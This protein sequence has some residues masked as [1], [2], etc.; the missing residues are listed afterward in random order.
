MPYDNQFVVVVPDYRARI[1]AA[2]WRAGEVTAEIE[3][4]E[5]DLELQVLLLT[6]GTHEPLPSISSPSA[7]GPTKLEVPKGTERVE[8]FLVRPTGDL[9]DH[10]V[11]HKSGEEF[12]AV[13]GEPTPEE[14]A[15][16]DF[17]AGEGQDVEFKPF[18]TPNDN[19]KEDEFIRT[20]VAFAN[21][22][23]GRLYVGVKDTGIPEGESAL[24][25]ASKSDPVRGWTALADRISHLVRE[26]VKPIPKINVVQ[27]RVFGDPILMVEVEP[28]VDGPC[29]THEN[30]VYVRKGATNRKPDP[31]T[32]LPHIGSSQRSAILAGQLRSF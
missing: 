30:D 12:E 29:A 16:A 19:G 21:S 23:G 2:D 17:R 26:K 7:T 18:V 5:R 8:L 9:A 28:S 24:C 1:R 10:V 3:G 13:A 32:E 15:L 20:I 6:G 11:L 14:R 27:L 25:R 22:E 4:T 31:R